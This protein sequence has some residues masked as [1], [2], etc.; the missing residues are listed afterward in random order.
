MKIEINEDEV[1]LMAIALVLSL[2][3]VFAFSSNWHD[4]NLD[5]KIKMTAPT[6]AP[7]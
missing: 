7:A 6:N 5:H 3:M 1:F 2:L 4:K